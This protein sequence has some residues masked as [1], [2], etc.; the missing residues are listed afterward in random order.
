MAINLD[1]GALG[2]MYNLMAAPTDRQREGKEER[3]INQLLI[4]AIFVL[5]K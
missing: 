3:K 1:G 2:D 4:A 5:C